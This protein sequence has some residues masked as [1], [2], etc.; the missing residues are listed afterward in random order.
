MRKKLA[1]CIPTY[2][3]SE[4]V[5]KLLQDLSGLT[6]DSFAIHIFDSSEDETTKTIVEKYIGSNHVTY[7]F[8]KGVKYSNEK[9]FRIYEAMAE[10]DADYVWIMN[11]HSVFNKEAL[12]AIQK[13]LEEEG[14]FYLLDVR[15]PEFSV[16]DFKNLDE[17]LLKAAWDL[18]YFG[19]GIVK[20][21]SFLSGVD[22]AYMDRKYLVL[23]TREYSQLGFYFERAA[24]IP[25][26]KAK[27]I[28]LVRDSM[29]DRM[30]YEK[31]SW[32]K[33]KFRIC[34]QVWYEVIM[35]LPGGYKQKDK[36]LRAMDSWYLSKFSLMELKEDGGY[37]FISFLKYRKFL[38]MIA[39]DMV[40]TAFLIALLPLGICRYLLT[41]ELL[42]R[43]KMARRCGRKVYIYGAG[44]HG[45]DCTNFFES[46]GIR[47]DGFLV[48][49]MAGN[50]ESIRD[51]PV[52]AANEK[53]EDGILVILAFLS[54]GKSSVEVKLDE[55]KAAGMDL[56]YMAFN[57]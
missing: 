46:C 47:H 19:A 37:G 12:E 3:R 40:K 44:R 42:S 43:V 45:V 14:D 9:I 57:A 17:F 31:P 36:A 13:S 8:V 27:K 6:D 39:P 20:R 51:Y 41:G 55:L 23:E 29:L 49:D 26:V 11:D 48:T 15:C 7:T 5:E 21:Q 1:L 34:T 38:E 16:T 33:E 53:L 30:R 2:N 24:Q 54:N 52:Y 22:W 4:C 28:G 10:S 25:G 56:D 32:Q 50:P 18:T 35:R